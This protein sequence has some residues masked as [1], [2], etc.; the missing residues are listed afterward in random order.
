MDMN[1]VNRAFEMLL[2][3]L[4]EILNIIRQQTDEH[5]HAE[6]FDKVKTLAEYAEQLKDLREKLKALQGEYQTILIRRLLNIFHLYFK[7]SNFKK[8]G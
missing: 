5:L 4:D 3:G 8:E 6:N 2:E 7:I 1:K